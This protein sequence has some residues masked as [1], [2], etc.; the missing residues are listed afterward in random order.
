[1][2]CNNED[3]ISFEAADGATLEF[4]VV[5]EFYHD[6]GKFAVLKPVDGADVALIAEI[7]DPEGPDEEFVP[8]PMKR[9]QVLLDYLNREGAED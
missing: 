1:M 9:Q 7:T 3:I 8:L 4:T 6:G 2:N 5:Y